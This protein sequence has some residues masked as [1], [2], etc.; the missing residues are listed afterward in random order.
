MIEPQLPAATPQQQAGWFGRLA[1]GTTDKFGAVDVTASADAWAQRM[2]GY[3]AQMEDYRKSILKVRPAATAQRA[4]PPRVCA[5]H[6]A[7]AKQAA[8]SDAW[9]EGDGLLAR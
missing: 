2:G 7:A 1:R 4:L 3:L 6:A 9:G 5:H 8:A